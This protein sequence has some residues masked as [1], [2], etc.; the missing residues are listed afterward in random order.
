MARTRR[1]KPSVV[2]ILKNY[3]TKHRIA[4]VLKKEIAGA[5]RK[6]RGAILPD[7]RRK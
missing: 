5:D 7:R 4:A 2:S 3:L 1:T 6:I